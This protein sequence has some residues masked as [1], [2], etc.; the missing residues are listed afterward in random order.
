MQ[1][2]PSPGWIRPVPADDPNGLVRYLFRFG[3][4][5]GDRWRIQTA[6]V[7]AGM[8]AGLPKDFISHPVT[9]SR[10]ELLE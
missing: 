8:E 10:K 1:E 7:G 5:T 6:G 9:D 2:K 4:E 3:V